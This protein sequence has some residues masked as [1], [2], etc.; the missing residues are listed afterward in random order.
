[1]NF[2]CVLEICSRNHIEIFEIFSRNGVG[3]CT[4]D[5][6]ALKWDFLVEFVGEFCVKIQIKTEI[7]LNFKIYGGED[8]RKPKNS[9]QR[10]PL[11]SPYLTLPLQSNT[12]LLKKSSNSI[13]K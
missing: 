6:F 8:D 5:F 3:V 9:F 1:M 10:N 13:P 4:L 11:S 2:F 12:N 7:W